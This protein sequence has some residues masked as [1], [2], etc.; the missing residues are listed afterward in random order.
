MRGVGGGRERGCSADA[1]TNNGKR[2]F[3]VSDDIEWVGWR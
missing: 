2:A 3:S 1:N